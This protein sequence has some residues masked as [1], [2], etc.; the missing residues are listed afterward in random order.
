[1]LNS[2]Q[3]CSIEAEAGLILAHF[4]RSFSPIGHF[5]SVG[6]S[7]GRFRPIVGRIRLIST[8]CGSNPS[9]LAPLRPTSTKLDAEWTTL[10]PNLITI[11]PHAAPTLFGPNSTN[12]GQ[13]RPG[14]AQIWPGIG[15]TWAGFDRV[16]ADFNQIRATTGGGTKPFLER[17]LSDVA[18]PL[19]ASV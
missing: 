2:G 16:W 11:G 13:N 4:A 14:V 15:H 9:K 6:P 17:L 18:Y 5:G 7:S 3:I 8:D 1:M 19:V 12:I 10:F